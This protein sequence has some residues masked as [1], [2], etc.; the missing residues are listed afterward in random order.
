[1]VEICE[2]FEHGDN[3]KEE[4]DNPD[5]PWRSSGDVDSSALAREVV[6]RLVIKV[7][8]PDAQDRL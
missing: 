2:P 1:M 7:S 3:G 4:A 8:L 5:H 6:L